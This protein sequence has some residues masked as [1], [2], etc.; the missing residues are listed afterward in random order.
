MYRTAMKLAFA[1][2]LSA[3]VAAAGCS[4][5]E[6][7]APGAITA[8]SAPANSAPVA[9]GAMGHGTHDPK[10]GGVVLMSDAYHFEVVAQPT[11]TYEIYFTDMA[12]NDLPATTAATVTLTV[13]R[14]GGAPPETIGLKIDES[15]EGWI[16]SGRP[17]DDLQNT[18]LNISYVARG[19]D[20]P[21]AMDIPFYT[22]QP[23]ATA[24]PN[25]PGT[26]PP[27]LARPAETK[28]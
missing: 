20:K 11:G 18:L 15:G 14:P 8:D 6:E 2:G 13:K 16:G 5:S 9:E 12:R 27:A 22:T 24:A 21:Y 1:A 23:G 4:S 3:V 28:P 19:A 7:V 25:A 10:H 26:P 17:V